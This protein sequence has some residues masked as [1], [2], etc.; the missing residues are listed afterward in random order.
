MIYRIKK[1]SFPS[2][3]NNRGNKKINCYECLKFTDGFIYVEL[4]KTEFKDIYCFVTSFGNEIN[5]C[6]GI[7]INMLTPINTEKRKK[8]FALDML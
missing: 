2:C 7:R 5:R 3:A 6:S 4:R 8:K 1:N